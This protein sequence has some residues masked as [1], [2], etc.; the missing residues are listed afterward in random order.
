MATFRLRLYLESAARGRLLARGAVAGGD[1]M[2]RRAEEGGAG[3]WRTAE[4]GAR[5]EM[6]R[7]GGMVCSVSGCGVKEAGAC[8]EERDGDER[9]NRRSQEGRRR[10]RRG[11]AR[12][13]R[14]RQTDRRTDSR[15]GRQTESPSPDKR[16][17][18]VARRRSSPLQAPSGP[19]PRGH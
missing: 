13:Q 12:R 16:P 19:L 15:T 5:G 7:G 10:E 2:G 6:G 9:T 4:S 3:A 11:P 8:K 18:D 14:D 17:Q 1:W